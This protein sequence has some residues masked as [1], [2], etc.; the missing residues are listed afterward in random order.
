MLFGYCL[1]VLQVKHD[2]LNGSQLSM[3]GGGG[4][5]AFTMGLSAMADG[6]RLLMRDSLSPWPKTAKIAAYNYEPG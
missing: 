2:G 3:S 4:G 1:T 6:N 5:G